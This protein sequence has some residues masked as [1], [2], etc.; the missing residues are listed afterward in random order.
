MNDCPYL[1]MFSVK[2]TNFLQFSLAG[3]QMVKITLDLQTVISWSLCWV[4]C[5]VVFFSFFEP[6]PLLRGI[7]FTFIVF[8]FLWLMGP[9]FSGGYLFHLCLCFFGPDFESGPLFDLVGPYWTFS[10]KENKQKIITKHQN[11][12]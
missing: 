12:V 2:K 7:W 8:T 4:S 11:T 9:I 3:R 10:K 1:L 6:P 5:G